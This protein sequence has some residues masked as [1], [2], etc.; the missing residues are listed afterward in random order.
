MIHVQVFGELSIRRDGVPLPPF[1]SRKVLALLIY[2]ALNPGAHSRSRLAGLLWS[3]S[4]EAKAL[5]NLRFA[6]WNLT[7]VLGLQVFEAD[8]LSVAWQNHPDIVLDVEEFL[9]ALWEARPEQAETPEVLQALERAVQG[10]RGEL[11]EG[12][13]LPDNVLF[14]ELSLIHI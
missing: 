1:K 4:P 12:F 13:E 14:N 6:L 7:Q 2:L 5:S 8:R 9:T 11:L 10:Y 3:D